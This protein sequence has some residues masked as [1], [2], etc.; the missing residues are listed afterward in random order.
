MHADTSCFLTNGSGLNLI[1]GVFDHLRNDLAAVHQREHQQSNPGAALHADQGRLAE[2]PMAERHGIAQTQEPQAGACGDAQDAGGFALEVGLDPFARDKICRQNYPK[3]QHARIAHDANETGHEGGMRVKFSLD[4]HANPADGGNG[5]DH[6]KFHAEEGHEKKAEQLHGGLDDALLKK[7]GKTGERNRAINDLHR[8]SAQ[9]DQD[10]PFEPLARAL[11]HDG[12]IDG[13][14]G[15]G[16]KE[17]AEKTCQRGDEDGR[18][19]GH[20][21]RLS[22]VTKKL[23]YPRRAGFDLWRGATKE[24]SRQRSVTEEQRS[25]RSKPARPSGWPSFSPLPALLAPY[26]PP[27]GML[28][29]RALAAAKNPGHAGTEISLSQY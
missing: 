10:T 22:T 24:H 8:R 1:M 14:D 23:R 16:K 20:A 3:Q 18:Q 4:A 21:W 26:R 2:F 11:V 28:V 27:A 13:A 12:E 7:T 29:A 9:A 25:Q 5:F 19:R 15:D 6:Q 17:T